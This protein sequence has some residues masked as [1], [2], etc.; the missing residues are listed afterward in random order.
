MSKNCT[1][2]RHG[3][4]QDVGYSCYTLEGQIF[5]CLESCNGE[6]N[7]LRG[8]A[9]VSYESYEDHGCEP[10]NFAED[11]ESYRQGKPQEYTVGD[12][13]PIV[14]NVEKTKQR[15]YDEGWY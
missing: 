2:C 12:V 9:S 13:L 1:N 11:C 15:E 3:A 5:L 8:G 7:E 14:E 6:L 4:I 10:Y